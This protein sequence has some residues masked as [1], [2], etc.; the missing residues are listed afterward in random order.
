MVGANIGEL[1]Q[2]DDQIVRRCCT[3]SSQKTSTSADKSG[4]VN[5]V[6]F[7]RRSVWLELSALVSDYHVIAVFVVT[8]VVVAVVA[9]VDVV[10]VT[11]PCRFTCI[12]I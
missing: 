2:F 3:K 5:N 6:K 8:V 1:R 12:M 9:V 10:A 11:I 4:T 7:T